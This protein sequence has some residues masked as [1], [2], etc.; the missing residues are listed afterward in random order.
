MLGMYEVRTEGEIAKL[1]LSHVLACGC[2]T[3]AVPWL[4]PGLL[5]QIING[6]SGI[7]DAS[8]FKRL[9]PVLLLGFHQPVVLRRATCNNVS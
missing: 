2:V 6:E 9:L 7:E 3:D 4:R 8:I 5:A 1:H